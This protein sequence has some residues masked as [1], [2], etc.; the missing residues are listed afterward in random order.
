M[1][2]LG[3]HLALAVALVLLGL[4]LEGTA[5]FRDLLGSPLILA[6]ARS[7]TWLISWCG[8]AVALS[9]NVMRHP[10]SGV[11]VHV[12]EACD[13]LG[14]FI[15]I[16]AGIVALRPGWRFGIAAVAL[17]FGL[18]QLFNLARVVGL[19]YLRLGPHALY[20]ATHLYVLPYATVLLFGCFFF[21][22]A[23]TI[24]G[25]AGNGP[26]AT[27]AF[28]ATPSRNRLALFA[29]AF[30]PMFGLWWFVAPYL[31]LPLLRGV[32][33][34]AAQ[35]FH[36]PALEAL[37]EAGPDRWLIQTRLLRPGTAGGL[38]DIP[39]E[40][41]LFTAAIPIALA[42]GFACAPRGL[43]T[44]GVLL[45]LA[46]TSVSCALVLALQ[47]IVAVPKTAASTKADTVLLEPAPRARPVAVSY[48]PQ[49]EGLV[50]SLDLARV[51]LVYANFFLLPASIAAAATL[52]RTQPREPA[53][54]PPAAARPARRRRPRRR[55]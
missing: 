51:V 22:I 31:L 39:L 36:G 4:S 20:D 38:I 10:A 27:A 52:L 18:I 48:R 53:G 35:A 12:T 33:S 46:A 49:S 9:G 45:A 55:G 16:A 13:G 26:A 19:F 25:S 8:G 21:H 24:S 42:A 40:P 43:R 37:A 11:E 29:A 3:A 50:A 23:R 6:I 7:A 34:A 1:R 47:V 14:V 2:A 54:P 28:A 17:L 15:A 30:L 32:S 44:R 5:A 41:R